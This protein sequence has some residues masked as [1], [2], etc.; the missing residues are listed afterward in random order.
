MSAPLKI[1]LKSH[2]TEIERI[3][4]LV[5]AFGE[6]HGL[7]AATIFEVNLA[8]DEVLTNIIAYAHDDGA[9]HEIAVRL[10]LAAGE[11]LVEVEDDGRPFNPLEVPEPDIH[12]PLAERTIGGLGLHLVRK[13][14]TGL[15]YRRQDGRNVLVMRK[16][17]TQ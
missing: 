13:L 5:T 16:T 9:E 3:S 11:L 14:M 10:A 17:V 7:P 4:H 12:Q 15:A 6:E 1:T 2:L 8:L